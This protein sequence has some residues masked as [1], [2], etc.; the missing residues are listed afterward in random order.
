MLLTVLVD[1]NKVDSTRG[2]ADLTKLVDNILQS[3]ALLMQFIVNIMISIF[4]DNRLQ[5]LIE[6]CSCILCTCVLQVNTHIQFV[7]YTV[8]ISYRFVFSPLIWMILIKII[9]SRD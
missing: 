6:S 7:G 5:I 9:Y 8:L 2:I 3:S 4:L 1:T